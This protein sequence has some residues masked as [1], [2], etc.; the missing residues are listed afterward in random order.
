MHAGVCVRA[1]ACVAST[2]KLNTPQT[3]AHFYRKET[4]LR[5]SLFTRLTMHEW[6]KWV[7]IRKS[8]NVQCIKACT[9]HCTQAQWGW[10]WWWGGGGEKKAAELK[11][12]SLQKTTEATAL[13]GHFIAS[14]WSSEVHQAQFH[15]NNGKEGHRDKRGLSLLL[16][17]FTTG[18]SVA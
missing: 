5:V 18:R 1:R 7:V 16:N 6:L 3:L 14:L 4:L 11:E 12:S 10:W 17:P 15:H 13:R 2:M 9:A 8:K